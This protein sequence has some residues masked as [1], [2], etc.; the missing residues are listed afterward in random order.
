MR[1]YKLSGLLDQGCR[2]PPSR[3]NSPENGQILDYSNS[4][5]I[6]GKKGQ[7][8]ALRPHPYLEKDFTLT[9]FVPALAMA[10]N[11]LNQQIVY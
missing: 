2:S 7:F 9:N 11:W 3:A 1:H 10:S 8:F 4:I 6:R 5:L